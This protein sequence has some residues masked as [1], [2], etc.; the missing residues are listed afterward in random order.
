VNFYD[1]KTAIDTLNGLTAS[2]DRLGFALTLFLVII[3]ILITYNTIRLS[4]F[5]LK[6]EIAVMRLVGASQ[7]YIRGPFVI[8]GIMYGLFSGA[9]TLLLFWPVTLWLGSVT[10][11]FFI[12]LN[13]FHYYI[14]NIFEIALVVFGSGIIIGAFSSWLA[15]RRYLKV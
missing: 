13:V 12:G 14:S 7:A 11:N 8:S 9:L 15:T 3:S 5:M 1:N 10:A 2:A 4:I 6:D